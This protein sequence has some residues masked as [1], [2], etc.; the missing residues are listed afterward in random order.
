MIKNEKV[1]VVI[2]SAGIGTRFGGEK[3]KQLIAINGIPILR[4]TIQKFQECDAVDFIVIASHFD[5]ID[6]IK[7]LVQSENLTKVKSVVV[8]GK[9]RQDSVWSGINEI[10]KFDVDILLIH[11]AVRP[12][13]SNKIIS[14]V[15]QAVKEYE[16]AIPA[17]APKD[18]IKISDNEG[19]IITT[20]DRNI[21]FAVQTPQGFKT[22][23]IVEAFQKAYADKFYGTDDSSLVERLGKKVKIIEGDYRN[24]KITTKEDFEYASYLYE[25]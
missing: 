20:P 12:F 11:D 24:I 9:H 3:P 10:V 21:L 19:F 16:V 17:V 1:G 5:Y 25:S 7:Q 15:I 14:N 2:P 23:I 18:T 13:V 6:D 8:G 22:K 4:L